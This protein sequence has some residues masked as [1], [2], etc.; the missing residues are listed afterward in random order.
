MTGIEPTRPELL[1]QTNGKTRME[2]VLATRAQRLGLTPDQLHEHDLRVL[3]SSNYPTTECL[4]PR[5]VERFFSSDLAVER[6][7]HIENC[8]MCA[9]LVEVADPPMRWFDEVFEPNLKSSATQAQSHLRSERWYPVL[10]TVRFGIPVLLFLFALLVGL[11]V[12]SKGDVIMSGLLRERIL[13]SSGIVLGTITG[14]LTLSWA[15]T[16]YLPSTR[17]WAG[18]AMGCVFAL[19]IGAYLARSVFQLVEGYDGVTTAQYYLLGSIAENQAKR[20]II[21]K[22]ASDK[23]SGYSGVLIAA[24]YR[25]HTNIYWEHSGVRRNLAKVYE[26]TLQY[27]PNGDLKVLTSTRELPA[28]V[29]APD[30]KIENGQ[31]VMALVPEKS[32][33]AARIFP[34]ESAGR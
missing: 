20:G 29:P 28:S 31:S 10:A 14:V 21:E 15:L 18:G 12:A 34:I 8:A 2:A 25:G 33:N 32:L 7:S 23:L 19:I 22:V 11:I 17:S 6:V 13:I 26:G 4:D 24:R 30:R 1:N 16:V 27:Q 5:E 9:T 3:R